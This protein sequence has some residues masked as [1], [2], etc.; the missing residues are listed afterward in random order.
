MH[1]SSF[2]GGRASSSSPLPKIAEIR[3]E[4]IKPTPFKLMILPPPFPSPHPS[5][6]H[7]HHRSLHHPSTLSKVSQ[8]IDELSTDREKAAAVPALTQSALK[9]IVNRGG[10]GGQGDGG[11]KSDKLTGYTPSTGRSR[12]V[13]RHANSSLPESPKVKT[14]RSSAVMRISQPVTPYPEA[15]EMNKVGSRIWDEKRL[16]DYTTIKGVDHFLLFEKYPIM[17]FD[18]NLIKGKY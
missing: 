5:S 18:A 1:I 15:F 7:R 11:D 4:P 13:T 9:M 8:F 17:Q 14:H 6:T 3:E 2:Y 12:L 10:Q 16:P